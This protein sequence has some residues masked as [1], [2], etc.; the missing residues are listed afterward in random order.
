MSLTMSVDER[1]QF[2]AGVHVGIIS[3]PRGK[4]GPLAVP[5]WY[6]YEP[7][8][9]PWMITNGESIKGRLIAKAKRISLCVQTETAPYQY[10]SIEGPFTV[11]QPNDGQLLSM[12][13]RYLGEQ[14]G[15]MYAEGSSV[16]AAEG[17]SA[18]AKDDSIIV[19]ISPETWYSVDYRKG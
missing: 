3:I 9:K 5:I 11:T 4:R 7:G 6:D 18:E 13:I 12:A 16:D 10:V 14:Q 15:K 17:S 19:S 8:G 1:Q 2:L